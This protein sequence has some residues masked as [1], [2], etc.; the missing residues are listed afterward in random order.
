MK[1]IS[2][3][4]LL[5]FLALMAIFTFLLWILIALAGIGS[6]S[7]FYAW[8]IVA[9][10]AVLGYVLFEYGYAIKSPHF[11]RTVLLGQAMRLFLSQPLLW[12]SRFSEWWN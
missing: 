6:H 3:K 11:F 5:D 12:H 1:L 4:P 9:T 7:V 10:N 2:A 8:A